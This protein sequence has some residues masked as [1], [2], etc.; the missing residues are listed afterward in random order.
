M[1]LLADDVSWTIT[2]TS[3]LAGTYTSQQQSLDRTIGRLE[4]RPA[5][6]IRPTVQSIVAEGDRVVLWQTN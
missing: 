4:A 6:P 1:E 5:E 3:A 2:G